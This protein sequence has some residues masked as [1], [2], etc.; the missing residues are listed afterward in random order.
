M[1]NQLLSR[2][3][4]VSNKNFKVNFENASVLNSGGFYLTVFNTQIDEGSIAD[5]C[6]ISF[7]TMKVD[8]HSAAVQYGATIYKERLTVTNNQMNTRDIYFFFEPDKNIFVLFNT[9]LLAKE[10]LIACGLDVN[11]SSDKIYENGSHFKY[12]KLLQYSDV[13]K[14]ATSG[15]GLEFDLHKEQDILETE[16]DRSYT[17][18][19]AEESFYEVLFNAT[20]KLTNDYNE[21]SIPLS[22]GIDSGS[23]AYLLTQLNKKV[24]AYTIGTEWGNEYE[25]AK[26]TAD[27][28][29]VS[30]TD[31]YITRD[32]I[33]REI[34]N[35][36]AAFGF[37]IAS[38]IEISLVP[39]CL[40][41]KVKEQKSNQ[42]ILFATGFGSDLLNAG[43][44]KPFNT[45]EE[46]R[47]DILDTL[48]KTRMPTETY[49]NLFFTNNS[50]YENIHVVH[51]FWDPEVIIEALKIAP[52][53]KVVDKKDKYFFRKMLENRMG[54]HN[55]WRKKWAAH[56][57]T[58]IGFNL[59]N[60]LSK[61]GEPVSQEEYEN[62]FKNI[63]K[64]IFYNNNFSLLK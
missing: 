6:R 59:R 38:N 15:S 2:A 30:L 41:R 57:G 20:K 49:S 52:E 3:F 39:Q 5:N 44:F 36:I 55:C 17:L 28:I 35:I 10:I 37:N 22:G 32:D 53:F 11:Y 61:T 25:D 45:Y 63:H 54:V 29:G 33:F 47:N 14:V 23:I 34:P 16:V 60:A 31:V 13:L 12:V 4:I 56:H 26:S 42:D 24:T 51:P 7:D 58:G 1:I 46:L 8:N 9:L 19:K 48:K 21:V 50:M 40:F 62:Y 43:I 27:Y 64:E 18:Q